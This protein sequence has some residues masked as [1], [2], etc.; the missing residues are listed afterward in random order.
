MFETRLKSD[1]TREVW[2]NLSMPAV[3]ERLSQFT[4]SKLAL[5]VDDVGSERCVIVAPALDISESRVNQILSVSGGLTF[6][7]ISP[8]RASALLLPLMSRETNGML[9]P[10]NVTRQYVSVEARE[11]VSTGI[12]A[13]D[14]AVTLR[15]LG[16][17]VPQPRALVKPGHIFPVETRE[18]GSLVKAAIPETALDIVTL[19]GFSDAAL[20][21]D[22]L[23]HK[24]EMLSCQAARLAAQE[25]Q[26]P[27]FS[28]SE[29]IQH[30]LSGEAL[31]SRS[32]EASL[33]TREAGELRAIVYRSVIHNVE[34]IALVKG[35]ISPEQTTLV[36]VQTEHTVSDVFGG[37]H[38]P[39]RQQLQH[40]LRCI[41]ERGSGVLLYLRRSHA[42]ESVRDPAPPAS[43]GSPAAA[44]R[45]YGV[46][47]QI[48]RDLGA[49]QIELISSTQK[50]LLGLSNFGISVKSQIPMPDFT[51]PTE[52]AL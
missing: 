16:A 31:V 45:E 14:R 52:P 20:F 40:S 48:L 46:G 34:H 3:S 33:P 50:T 19:S 26:A 21:M 17:P 44:M 49:T 27:L 42:P 35:S 10:V 4:I 6:V 7:A 32:A 30:R 13:A 11:G 47:A 24:G 5:L 41:G 12:S 9:S 43:D 23:D 25:L 29:I 38:P 2:S 36:R 18:G 37:H 39:S 51:S 22:L 28:I 15:V 1:T 8:Q